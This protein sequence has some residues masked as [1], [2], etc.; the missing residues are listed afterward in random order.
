LETTSIY[1]EL[2]P[3]DT[4]T[5]RIKLRNTVNSEVPVSLSVTGDIVPLI[6]F[7]SSNIMLG[8]LERRDVSIKIIIPK[9][10]RI[11]DYD[12]DLVVT[13]G[14]EEG[15]IPFTIKVLPPEGKLLDV[16]V[17]PLTPI[18]APG[19]ILRL[20]VDLLNL[21]KTKSVDV[22]FDLQLVDINTGDI[23]TRNEEAFAVETSLS[24]V[25]NLTVPEW[26]EPGRY[27]VKAV[28][29]YSNVEL[30]G[31]MQ[32][33]SIAYVQV[34]HRFFRRKLLGVYLWVWWFVL[35]GIAAAI[36]GYYLWNW[37]EYRKKRFK[38]KLDVGKLPQ[39]SAHSEF[40]GKVAETGIR[41]FVD[42]NKLQM[43]TLIA[44]ATGSGKT[45]AAMDFIEAALIKK[46][47]VIIFDPTAQWTGFLRKCEDTGMLKRYKYFEMKT[48]Q[49]RAFDGSIKTIHDPYEM[50][51]IAKYMDR[52]G[53]ISIF[54][55]SNLTPKEI[56]IV[57]ASTIEQIF[58]SKPEESKELKTLIVYDEVH[59]LLPK[60]GGS[61]Q[62]FVQLERGAREFR[63]WGIGLVL[64]SQVLSDF[65]GEIK[66]NIG[67]EVQMGT[68]YEGDLERVSMKYGDDVLKSVVKE[69]IGTGMNVNA[70]YNNGRPY[71]VSYRPLLHGTK[72]LT[73]DELKKYE[74]YF[75]EMEDFDYQ[76]AELKKLKV[77]TMDVELEIKLSKAKVKSGQFQ[78]ADMYL[79][80][81]RPKLA[82]HW[83]KIG[84]EPIHIVR[85]K[86][87]RS[88]VVKGIQ[89]AK[90]ERAKY[91][92]KNP[93]KKISFKEEVSGLK[94]QMESLKKKGK[95]TSGIEIRVK[96]LED[97]LK[98]FKGAIP[99]EDSQSIA[100]EVN[101][102]KRELRG[103]GKQAIVKKKVVAEKG[104]VKKTEE[105]K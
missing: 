16:K 100:I 60:F 96:N 25:K 84:K 46:K 82:E 15:M 90:I 14:E 55:V 97:R 21:G 42:L 1:K 4:A 85:K 104:N 73:N 49:A 31:T 91:I 76:A 44:G 95:D 38:V 45:V 68:R 62:G 105:K 94:S 79:E 6:F 39:A 10:A 48:G 75:A 53:E 88:E 13:S 22:Q 19:E 37:L 92:K 89:A 77:D 34:Q 102:L 58:K 11:G 50:I 36:G 20:Q 26:V 52:P 81:L 7:E 59:R 98:P 103:L 93:E 2:F 41:T 28:A 71:F 80:T 65:V 87:A 70:E 18:V 74:K 8:A 83:K 51:E 29:Y 33:S 67:T 72:R 66:A 35:L 12:G 9:F 78:M 32:A 40:I 99:A 17:Q 86:I 56:D 23:V 54:N 27:M 63:K 57:V 3:G 30:E 69:P 64:I 47:S 24:T 101:E 5:V 61:G 43:H